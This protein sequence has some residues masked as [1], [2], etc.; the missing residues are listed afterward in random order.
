MNPKQPKHTDAL[1]Q[2]PRT[3]AAVEAYKETGEQSDPLGMWTGRPRFD[4]GLHAEP[5]EPVQD[6]DDL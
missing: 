2:L 1:S 4:N 6:A 3:E 5:M